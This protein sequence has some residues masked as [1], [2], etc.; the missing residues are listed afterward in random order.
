VRSVTGQAP[1]I[2]NDDLVSHL[3]LAVGLWSERRAGAEL[4]AG[5]VEQLR[6]HVAGED[7]TPIAH[8]RRRDAMEPNDATE[9]CLGDGRRRIGVAES[10]EVVVFGESDHQITDLP[11]T[12]GKP[13]T[14][15]IAMSL[16]NVLGTASSCKRPVG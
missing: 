1:E 3:G 2:H 11:T 12:F 8:D 13:S 14:K 5:E 16:H 10:D 4:G 6:P 9:E 15:S 7:G